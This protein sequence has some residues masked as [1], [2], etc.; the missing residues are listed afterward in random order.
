MERVRCRQDTSN[1]IAVMLAEFPLE[2]LI[3]H[4]QNRKHQLDQL[5]ACFK[6][7]QRLSFTQIARMSCSMNLQQVDH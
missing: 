5:F 1:R 2:W 7:K 4:S 6:C 3:H